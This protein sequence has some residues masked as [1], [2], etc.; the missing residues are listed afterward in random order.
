MLVYL[1]FMNPSPSVC[2][3]WPC[4][5]V[6]AWATVIEISAIIVAG[7]IAWRQLRL[8]AKTRNRDSTIAILRYLD[9][10]AFGRARWFLYEHREELKT[11]LHPQKPF[12]W[13]VKQDWEEIFRNLNKGHRPRVEV[14]S[15]RS[16]IHALDNI[17]FLINQGYVDYD[18]IMPQ[19]MENHFVIADSLLS[20]YIRYSLEMEASGVLFKVPPGYVP[21]FGRNFLVLMDLIKVRYGQLPRKGV[22]RCFHLVKTRIEVA[23]KKLDALSNQPSLEDRIKT[24]EDALS[25][26]AATS[27]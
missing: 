6:T 17:A 12:A 10:E 15:I 27:P 9:N 24:L 2:G 7:W 5:V 19:M 3:A 13:E 14:Y 8:I 22:A 1:F 25:K 11:F 20:D 23:E 16:M 4:D 18:E 21:S 26:K